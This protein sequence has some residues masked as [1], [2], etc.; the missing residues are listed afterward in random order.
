[1]WT[2][3][4]VFILLGYTPASLHDSWPTFQDSVVIS[5]SRVHYPINNVGTGGYRNV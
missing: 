1:M 2:G 3:H 5:S 4:E